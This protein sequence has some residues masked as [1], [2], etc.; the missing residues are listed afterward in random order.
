MVQGLNAGHATQEGNTYAR[1]QEQ[2]LSPVRYRTY[3]R[4]L[5]VVPSNRGV[6]QLASTSSAFMETEVRGV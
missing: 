2:Y 6:D 1:S 4:P 3:S 5:Y